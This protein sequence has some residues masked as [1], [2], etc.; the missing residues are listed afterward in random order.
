MRSLAL[1][2]IAKGQD[3]GDHLK[4]LARDFLAFLEAFELL[5]EALVAV[6]V[7][8][9]VTGHR[10]DSI[11]HR[12][13]ALGG[14]NWRG[15]LVFIVADADRLEDLVWPLAFLVLAVLARKHQILP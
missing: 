13:L 5:Q 8:A 11:G 12:A 3:G 14:D 2:H 4:E 10:H 7:D 6:H 15:V 1:E 9:E